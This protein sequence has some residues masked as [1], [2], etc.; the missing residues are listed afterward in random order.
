YLRTVHD[1]SIRPK[2]RTVPGVAE[3]NSWGGYEK[4]YHVRPEPELLAAHGLTFADVLA[5]LE[6]NNRDVGGG[7]IQ[8]N[9]QFLLV[10]GLG[11]PANEEQ[12]RNIVVSA[13]D[14]VP[15]RVR[16]VAEVAVGSELRR[17]SVTA[18]GRG[19]AVLGLCFMTMG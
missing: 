11:R 7:G 19:E 12:L 1:W 5:A 15:V 16:D 17:G 18:E 6:K 14:G 10:Q 4:Q 9:N 2:L 13:K 3:V 8:K